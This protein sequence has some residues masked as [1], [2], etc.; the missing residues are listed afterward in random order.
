LPALAEDGKSGLIGWVVLAAVVLLV[1]IGA[2]VFRNGLVAA[3]PPVARLY[4]TLGLSLDEPTAEAPAAVAPVLEFKDLQTE[5]RAEGDNT[6]LTVSGIIRNAG[7]QETGVPP[8]R[9]TLLDAD[10]KAVF[11]WA[12]KPAQDHIAPGGTLAFETRA[13]NPPKAQEVRLT[14]DQEGH[15]GDQ[16]VP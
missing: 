16:K 3:W 6:V 14:F 11:D 2:V 10:Q 8:V 9:V 15:D 7:T 5:L 13:T 4:H 12:F 1:C